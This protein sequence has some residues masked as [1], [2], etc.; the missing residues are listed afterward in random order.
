M[1][2]KV[3]GDIYTVRLTKEYDG[4]TVYFCNYSSNGTILIAPLSYGQE[5]L[6]AMANA[7]DLPSAISH[8][9]DE[10]YIIV[11]HRDDDVIDASIKGLLSGEI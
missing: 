10:V 2:K 7:F 5:R 4:R 8:N 9:K 6:V 1:D 3:Y 11:G